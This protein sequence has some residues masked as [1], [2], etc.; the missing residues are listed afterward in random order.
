MI[1]WIQIN[2]IRNAILI[3]NVVRLTVQINS[4]LMIFKERI[5]MLTI[6]NTLTRKK[7]EVLFGSPKLSGE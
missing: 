4:L 3:R 2:I 6:Y 1:F 7:E 5:D